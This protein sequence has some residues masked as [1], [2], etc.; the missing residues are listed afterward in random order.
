MITVKDL[1]NWTKGLKDDELIGIDEGGLTLVVVDDSEE[2]RLQ[3]LKMFPSCD[4]PYI[5]VGGLPI[6]EE[7]GEDHA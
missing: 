6:V 3:Q 7:E 5:E 2:A 4:V 1:K